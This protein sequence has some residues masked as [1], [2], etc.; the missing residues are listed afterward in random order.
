MKRMEQLGFTHSDPLYAAVCRAY[1]A[2]H[3]LNVEIHYLSC[4]SGVGARLATSQSK[5]KKKPRQCAPAG[6]GA[7]SDMW[8]VSSPKNSTLSISYE[9]NLILA[10]WRP[11]RCRSFLP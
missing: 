10:S 1:D 3:E 11:R 4:E 5:G 8:H 6:C 2:M 9:A 7:G